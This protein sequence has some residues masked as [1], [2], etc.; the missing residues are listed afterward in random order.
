MGVTDKL[1]FSC[2]FMKLIQYPGSAGV[3]VI[4]IE[5]YQTYQMASAGRLGGSLT[6]RS[7][8]AVNLGLD[9]AEAV[10]VFCCGEETSYTPELMV[11]ENDLVQAAVS[12]MAGLRPCRF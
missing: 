3:D 12:R 8:G 4:L 7:K 10:R 1:D 5:D 11:Q 6:D 2:G 9:S